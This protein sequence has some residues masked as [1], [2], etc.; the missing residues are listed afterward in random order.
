MVCTL[1]LKIRS[2][3]LELGCYNCFHD[4]TFGLFQYWYDQWVG[5]GSGRSRILKRGVPVCD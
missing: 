2:E 3:A 1:T 5:K 4:V